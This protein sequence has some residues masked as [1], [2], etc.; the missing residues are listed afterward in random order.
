MKEKLYINTK[1]GELIAT[2]NFI[3]AFMVFKKD[4]RQ[5]GYKVHLKDIKKY[6]GTQRFYE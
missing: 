6:K 3:K 4:S 1:T 5:I 2:K